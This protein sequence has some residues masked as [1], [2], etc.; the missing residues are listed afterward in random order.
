MDQFCDIKYNTKYW[1][2]SK[3]ELHRVDGPAVE[4]PNGNK[5]WYIN[6]RAHREDGPSIEW[7]NGHAWYINGEK[8]FCIN[9]EIKIFSIENIMNSICIVDQFGNK[10]WF[11]SK[12]DFHRED[13]P[14]C[15]YTN[16]DKYWYINGKKH[17]VNLPAVEWASGSKLWYHNGELHR[18]DGPAIEYFD[19]HNSWYINGKQIF[20]INNEE[21]IRMI[22]LKFFIPL[23]QENPAL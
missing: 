18:E 6:G 20:C 23:P 9:D 21:F 14:A 2:N 8:I 19:G 7:K 1:Y 10:K 17:R 22:K 12:G 3:M 11:N 4:Y 5:S 13:G 15:E 16:G